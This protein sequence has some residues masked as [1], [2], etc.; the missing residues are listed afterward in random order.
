MYFEYYI[1]MSLRRA[2]LTIIAVVVLIVAG[3]FG[4]SIFRGSAPIMPEKLDRIR[5][6]NIYAGDRIVSPL[7]LSGEARG[8]WFFEASF[9]IQ[10]LAED[11]SVIAYAIAQADGD[12]MTEAFVPFRAT[13]SFPPQAGRGTL[14]FIRDNPSGLPEYDE[15]LE[16]PI[17]F[18]QSLIFLEKIPARRGVY[19]GYVPN[20]SL[21]CR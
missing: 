21:K 20:N 13:L 8:N 12:W 11:K 5:I 3:I 19:V 4:A 18:Q 16:V 15:R 1:N 7:M 17:V 2:K 10:L 9:P 14:V 6:F